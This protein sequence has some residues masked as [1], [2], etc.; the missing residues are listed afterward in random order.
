MKPSTQICLVS[1][2][3]VKI[4]ICLMFIFQPEGASLLGGA[5]ANASEAAETRKV[6][7]APVSGSEGAEKIDLNFIIQKMNQLRKE[8]RDLEKKKA[9][10]VAIQ[11]E[12]STKIDTLSKL[13]SEIK[14][15]MAK[16]EMIEQQKV[17]HLI[18]AYSAMKP[19]Q[20]A[21]L[22]ERLDREF[23]VALLSKMKGEDVGRILS[24]VKEEKAARLVEA[25]AKK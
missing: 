23:A 5:D 11:E 16:K 10:L 9:E 21:S 12:I 19:Q 24:F 3:T 14:S 22:I 25:L 18:K 8:E 2:I 1:L 6:P 17:K 20:A 13:R 4:L 15:Q 7:A